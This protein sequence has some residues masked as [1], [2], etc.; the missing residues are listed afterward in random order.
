MDR[1]RVAR[2]GAPMADIA[3]PARY[4]AV[5]RR[6][7]KVLQPA[8]AYAAGDCRLTNFDTSVISS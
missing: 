4:A 8:D 3:D 7:A 6:A 2:V 5:A 1:A